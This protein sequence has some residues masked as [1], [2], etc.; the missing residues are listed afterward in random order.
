MARQ[1]KSKNGVTRFMGQRS[2]IDKKQLNRKLR[3]LAVPIAIQGI[4]SSTLSL[5]D[6]LMVGF[7]GET[8]LASVGVASQVFMIFYLI[9]FGMMGGFATFASQYYGAGDKGSIRK[10]LG[11]AMTVML[12][13][14]T[15]FFVINMLNT[16]AIMGFY[17]KDPA[18]KELAVKYVRINALSFIL[19]GIS[20][21]LEMGFRATQ[22]TKVPLVV[23][24]V[25]FSTNTILNYILI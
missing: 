5:V 13:T 22:Q 6:N 11:L 8:E 12:A 1:C 18:V 17:T 24:T 21:P 3:M 15:L 16:D 20:G 19:L 9:N 14:G 25:T 10:V 23:S 2:I 7:L 4:V